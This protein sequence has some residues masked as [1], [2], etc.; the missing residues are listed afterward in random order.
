LTRLPFSEYEVI[1]GQKMT[2]TE[3][4]RLEREKKKADRD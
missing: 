4:E 1:E 2:Q 3:K